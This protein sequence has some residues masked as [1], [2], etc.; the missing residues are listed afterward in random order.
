MRYRIYI[1]RRQEGSFVIEA[2]TKEDAL[3]KAKAMV[4]CDPV[5][6]GKAA[7]WIQEATTVVKY[8]AEIV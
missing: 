4:T 1:K 2:E 8:A 5:G 7:E 6:V 3:G